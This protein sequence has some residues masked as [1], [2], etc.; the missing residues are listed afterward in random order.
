MSS[1]SGSNRQHQG[2][3]GLQ[4]AIDSH[5]TGAGREVLGSLQVGERG[6]VKRV[7]R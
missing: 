2:R 3:A 7:R 5:S 6:D 4:Q 1:G